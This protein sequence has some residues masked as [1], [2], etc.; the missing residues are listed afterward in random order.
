MKSNKKAEFFSVIFGKKV[1]LPKTNVVKKFF[2]II[3]HNLCI[4]VFHF[5]FFFMKFTS[6]GILTKLPKFQAP[7]EEVKAPFSNQ[8]I[9]FG[10]T[11]TKS[12]RKRK[13]FSRNFKKRK[14][15]RNSINSMFHVLMLSQRFIDLRK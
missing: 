7:W 12:K 3:S 8:K 4:F 10:T 2:L 6:D 9:N 11:T 15:I 1:F 14:K 13:S 5:T